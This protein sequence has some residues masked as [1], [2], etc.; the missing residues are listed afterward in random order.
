MSALVRALAEAR[1]IATEI[2]GVHGGAGRPA[3]IA[4]LVTGVD[5]PVGAALARELAHRGLAVHATARAVTAAAAEFSGSW[6]LA[7]GP[8]DPSYL[9]VLRRIVGHHRPDIV[10]PTLDEELPLWAGLR[11]WPDAEVVVAGAGPVSLARDK[12]LICWQLTSHHVPTPPCRSPSDFADTAEALRALGGSMVL[13]ARRPE[14]RSGGARVVRA[15]DELD[16][17]RLDDDFVVQPVASGPEYLCVLYRPEGP[18]R[19]GSVVYAV[20]HPSLRRGGLIALAPGEAEAVERA[21]WAAVRSLGVMGPAEV[22]VR[23]DEAGGVFVI[24]LHPR[25]GEH[26]A[27][28]LDQL[29]APEHVVPRQ[30]TPAHHEPARRG[31]R[32]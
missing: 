5:R 24:S 11:H 10:I 26:C 20:A 3:G 13:R 22:V 32:P 12:L 2:D 25:F 16:W 1:R 4:V 29:S 19:K 17:A 27:E 6:H 14:H 30:R 31:E 28:L 18:V 21:A 15:A 23:G 7:P 9:P 8:E